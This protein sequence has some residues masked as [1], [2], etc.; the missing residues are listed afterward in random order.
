MYCNIGNCFVLWPFAH[1]CICKICPLFQCVIYHNIFFYYLKYLKNSHSRAY[2]LLSR[3]EGEQGD[4]EREREREREK[5]LCERNIDWLSPIRTPTW[6][7]TCNILLYG[8][9]FQPPG[10]HWPGL[11]QYFKSILLYMDSRIVPSFWMSQRKLW[12]IA[13]RIFL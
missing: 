10:P 13:G 2:S 11:P 9:V 5:H 7:Q 8:T 4:R 12:P 3:G 6:D 1:H